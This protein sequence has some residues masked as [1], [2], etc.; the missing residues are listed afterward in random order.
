MLEVP[1]QLLC[2][3]WESTSQEATASTQALAWHSVIAR[4]SKGPLL[5]DAL[6]RERTLG[7][8]SDF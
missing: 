7:P 6:S 2:S 8:A 5:I 4:A 3:P 1:G